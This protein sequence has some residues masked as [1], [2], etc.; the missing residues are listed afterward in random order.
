MFPRLL[1]LSLLATALYA[2]TADINYRLKTNLGDIDITLLPSVAPLT[3]QNF[4]RYA[5][6]GAY[7]NAVFHRA[8]PGFILQ[9]GGFTLAGNS[10][11]NPIP[12]DPP[13]RNEFNLSNTRGTIAM[14]KLG[15]NPNSATNQ[16]FF[17]LADNSANLNNQNGGFTVFARVANAASQAVVDRIASQPIPR[18]FNSPFDEM[19]LLNYRGGSVQAAN[20]M[21]I[22]TVTALEPPTAPAIAAG[23]AIAPTA[24]GGAARTAPGGWLEI[25]GTNLGERTRGW[26][27]S[28][29]NGSIAPTMLESV[30]VTVGGRQA[31]VSY[32]S[33]TQIN[34]QLPENVTPG[35]EVP[36]V[37]SFNGLASQPVNIVVRAAN[38]N[39]L[40]PASF[41]VGD[42]QYVAALHSA[43]GKFVAND[44]IP[45]VE[46]LPAERGETLIFYG[47][48]FGAV[49]PN[50]PPLGGRRAGS[51]PLQI[52]VNPVSFRI[53][54][55]EA[56]AAFGG[57]A[58]G[59]V[60]LYQFNV[61]VPQGA[62]S[63]D[64]TLVVTQNNE[65]I[66]QQ[67]KISIK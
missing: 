5:N 64:Q 1:G 60:G 24:F 23:G 47:T 22:Q 33:P 44:K 63:G 31:F 25:Y 66:A 58:P 61:E 20:I 2:Q 50:F 11:N 67:L 62:Q 26:A 40:A 35:D 43:T 65:P 45:G 17:N 36:V 21:V 48:G 46:N 18:V 29:F 3:V 37:V 42:T 39:L 14:A 54:D 12:Q 56:R 51:N 57:L 38:G 9:T 53:G 8:V 52:L 13:V 28:D 32:V 49:T 4:L 19:P 30:Q 55:L 59:F 15:N 10:F 41:K 6:R 16:F 7:N 27:E 34:A